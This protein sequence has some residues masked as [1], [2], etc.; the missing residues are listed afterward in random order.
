[1]KC[2]NS[3][4]NAQGSRVIIVVLQRGVKIYVAAVEALSKME[5]QDETQFTTKI[6]GKISLGLNYFVL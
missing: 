5:R 1:V 4:F 6:G 2:W 3:A